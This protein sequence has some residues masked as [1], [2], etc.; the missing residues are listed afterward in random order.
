MGIK[1]ETNYTKPATEGRGVPNEKEALKPEDQPIITSTISTQ[2][3]PNPT[4]QN[5]LTNFWSY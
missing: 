4:H 5:I 3:K 1:E 2:D